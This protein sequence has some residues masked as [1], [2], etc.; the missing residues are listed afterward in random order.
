[1][2]LDEI[3]AFVP[4][5]NFMSANSFDLFIEKIFKHFDNKDNKDPE[6]KKLLYKFMC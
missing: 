6:F 3:S 4:E 1:M 2:G 5:L